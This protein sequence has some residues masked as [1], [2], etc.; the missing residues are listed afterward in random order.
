MR[1]LALNVNV[2]ILAVKRSQEES[3]VNDKIDAVGV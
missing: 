1:E 3:R 2:E